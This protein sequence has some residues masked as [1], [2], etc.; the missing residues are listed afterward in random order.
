METNINIQNASTCAHGIDWNS[1]CILC[2]RG[3]NSTFIHSEQRIKV[4]PTTEEIILST[5]QEIL[6][7]LK[8]INKR[9]DHIGLGEG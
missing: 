1:T 9:I 8:E 6:K 5:L 3:I 7:E 2:G 4:L